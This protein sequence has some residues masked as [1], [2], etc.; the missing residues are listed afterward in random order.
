MSACSTDI[1]PPPVIW[2]LTSLEKL[3]LGHQAFTMIPDDIKELKNLNHLD[4]TCNLQLTSL[5]AELG[6]L[7][8]TGKCGR[9]RQVSLAERD[10]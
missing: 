3:E 8:L 5:S 4:L 7:P 9:E 1:L 10:R 2:K 6:G